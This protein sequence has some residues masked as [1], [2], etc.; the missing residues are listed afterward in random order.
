[1]RLRWLTAPLAI[2]A[3][4][5][6]VAAQINPITVPKGVLRWDFTGRFDTWDYRWRDGGREEA[7]AAFVS[8][9]F[10][11]PAVQ[12]LADATT[13]LR[14]LTGI[15]SLNLSLGRSIA[16]EIVNVGTRGIGGAFGLTK[17]ITIFGNVPIVSVKIESRFLLDTNT[18]NVGV[19]PAASLANFLGALQVALS[20]LGSK[21]ARGDFNNDLALKSLAESRLAYGQDLALLIGDQT[22]ISS[23]LPTGS[24]AAGQALQSRIQAFFAD[25][26]T[27]KVTA[28]GSLLL[29]GRRAT[30]ANFMD[31][32]T[33]PSGP[34]AG[35]DLGDTPYLTRLGDIEVGAAILLVDRFPK[36]KFGTGFRATLDGTVRLRTAQLDRADKFLDIGTGDRQP[37]VDVNLTTDFAFGRFG[38]RMVGGYNLQLPG[39]Q[40]RRISPPDQPIASARVFA[41]VRRDPGDVIRVSARPFF[42]LATY[43]SIYGAADYWRRQ[44]DKFDYVAG[45]PPIAGANLSDLAVGTKSDALLLSGG[46]S[47]NHAGQDKLGV[48]KLPLD[49]SLRYQ[50]ILRSTTGIVPDASTVQIELRFYTRLW[51]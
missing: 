17:G 45:Q 31:Y 32:L 16:S 37:D 5:A 15:E 46:I 23:F 28:S 27:L 22:G 13:R 40:N 43:L 11:A 20:T 47:Y 36:I 39:N 38:L 48:F 1:M 25:L 6:Q 26:A 29:P 24:S 51:N 44:S 35:S 8:P 42:R 9:Q 14:R 50:R 34:V 7:A 49:A 2:A 3:L 19:A 33:D 10:G 21:I 18:S 4:A 12:A 30:V 41:G